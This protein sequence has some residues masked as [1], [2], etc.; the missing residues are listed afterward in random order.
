M[1]ISPLDG[2]Y[3]EKISELSQFISEYA[4]I[5]YRTEIEIKYLLA[6]SKIGVVRKINSIEQKKL[7]KILDNLDLNEALK[8]KEIEG[9][10]IRHKSN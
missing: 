4:L 10:K 2:R 7:I 8:I 9:N 5:K 6:L 3:I 1:A